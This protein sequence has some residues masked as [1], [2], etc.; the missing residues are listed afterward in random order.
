MHTQLEHQH[1]VK[2]DNHFSCPAGA[3]VLEGLQNTAAL[4][5]G[6]AL[7]AHIQIAIN[8][9]SLLFF[10]KAAFQSLVP[11][12]VHT[13]WI[14]PSQVENPPLFLVQFHVVDHCPPL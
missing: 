2:M 1:K 13:T 14:I 3:A 11:Q 8:P 7:L 9:N 10:H 12:L 5:A 4:L 6:R